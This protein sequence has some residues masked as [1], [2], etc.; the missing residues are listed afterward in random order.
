M[1]SY[2]ETYNKFTFNLSGRDSLVSPKSNVY[3]IRDV[4]YTV[5]SPKNYIVD[6]KLAAV[7]NSNKLFVYVKPS[8]TGSLVSDATFTLVM[9]T[10]LVDSNND[11]SFEYQD[12]EAYDIDSSIDLFNYIRDKGASD[13]RPVASIIQ[14]YRYFDTTINKPIW[15][16][17]TKW[18]DA[19]GIEV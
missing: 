2:G 14:G 15:W 17:G 9:H 1:G 19:T 12:N 16:T 3:N 8:L 10:E 18:V 4:F 13:T 7:Y 5:N 11:V 6:F